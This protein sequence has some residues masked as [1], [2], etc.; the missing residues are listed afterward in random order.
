MPE[1]R[2]RESVGL[3]SNPQ[4]VRPRSIKKT[5]LSCSSSFASVSV[6]KHFS[7]R[8]NFH[9]PFAVGAPIYWCLHMLREANVRQRHSEFF[10]FNFNRWAV[11]Y[12]H[13]TL[14]TKA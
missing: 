12:T 4:P 7:G 2:K 9:L 14:P 5:P 3:L 13:L 11:S 8:I 1:G 10:K 6:E